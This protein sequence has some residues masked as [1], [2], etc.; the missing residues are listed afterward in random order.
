MEDM[1][2]DVPGCGL[3]LCEACAYQLMEEHDGCLEGLVT[4]LEEEASPF[5]LRADVEFLLARGE[6]LQRTQAT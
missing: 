3:V 6:L 1:G 2:S 4:T 5:G